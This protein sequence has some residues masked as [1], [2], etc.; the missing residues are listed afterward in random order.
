[1]SAAALNPFRRSYLYCQRRAHEQ[2]VI[3]YSLAIGAV[4]PVAVVVVPSVRKSWFG[5]KPVERP[6]TTYPLPNRAREA[7][8][9]GFEDGWKPASA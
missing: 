4:G 9:E 1:M 3:F 6:P 5:W 7:T 8:V 2:P